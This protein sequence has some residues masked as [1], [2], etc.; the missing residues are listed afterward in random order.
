[1]Y[2]NFSLK[3]SRPAN[4]LNKI[5]FAA[6]YFDPPF[7]GTALSYAPEKNGANEVIN[8]SIKICVMEPDTDRIDEMDALFQS[9]GHEVL[10]L[11]YVIGASND[12]RSF[13]PDLLLLDLNMPT[14]SGSKLINVLRKNLKDLPPTILYTKMEEEKLKAIAKSTTVDSYVVKKEDYLNIVSKIKAMMAKNFGRTS[15]TVCS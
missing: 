15:I 8:N 6:N 2:A 13:A 12:I 4:A 5:N 3:D 14:I 11:N 10:F 7:T 9:M 1:M